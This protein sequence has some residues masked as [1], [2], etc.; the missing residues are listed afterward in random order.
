MV[1]VTFHSSH[2]DWVRPITARNAR[3]G[4]VIGILVIRADTSR[5][6]DSIT[7]LISIVVAI[8]A[9]AMA[10]AWLIS[11]RLREHI[12][13][14]L[15]ELARSS[16]AI[17]NGDL[18]A[19][20]E[21]EW[22]DEVGLLAN[23][24]GRMRGRLRDLVAQLR[25]SALAVSGEAS[26]LG[27]ASDAMFVEARRQESAAS[28]TIESI[29]RMS[30]S[31]LQ[32]SSTAETL[33]ET[34]ADSN[35]AVG[36]IDS[37]V[38]HAA[39]SI[40]RVSESADSTA[41]SVLQMT[42]AIREIA[43][44]ADHLGGAT[45]K[46]IDSMA[47]LRSSVA[48]VAENARR[49]FESTSQ[50]A[51]SARQGEAAVAASIYGMKGIEESFGGLET[52]IGELAE[53]SESI[54]EVLQVIEGVVEQTNLLALNAAIISS[55]AGEYGKAFAVVAREMKS[56]GDRTQN[57]TR[58]IADSVQLVQRGME[59]AVK[60][61]EMGSERVREG[62]QRSVEAGKALRKIRAT[63]E[64]SS[65]A[66][67]AIVTATASQGD[68]IQAVADELDRVRDLVGQVTHATQEQSNA[69]AE[70]QR[71]VET[72]R[73]LAGDLKRSTSEQTRQSRLTAV[74]VEQ[75]VAGI[76]QIHEATAEQR[77]DVALILEAVQVFEDGATETTR[78]AEE[79][80]TTVEALS[81]RSSGLETEVGRFRL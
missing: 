26:R 60:A 77:N 73:Q 22:D 45:G 25:E 21:I 40:E 74:A 10:G 53:R 64:D 78:R 65:E 46:T 80:K 69:S 76:A 12:A 20:I 38:E 33:A 2:V 16:E 54:H 37:A 32:V 41:S 51:E 48:D 5:L 7:E 68:G 55:Q 42:A 23:A 39:H 28:E 66:V 8:A 59:A 34:A 6:T 30:A 3:K 14:P 52:I 70:I 49:T 13:A 56:L 19:S 35:R 31:V 36:E 79:M 4:G 18:S 29:E 43:E 62:T 72:V 9:C 58:E 71:S 1:G 11:A 81:E 75:L 67:S 44:N 15:A 50:A 47:E 27:E 63:A 57:S 24:F 61:T 17:S